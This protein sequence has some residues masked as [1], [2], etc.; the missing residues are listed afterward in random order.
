MELTKLKGNTY[1]VDG[2]AYSLLYVAG[3]GRCILLDCPQFGEFEEFDA[4]LTGAGL[5]PAAAILSHG[6][7]D[8]S[9]CLHLLQQKY[10]TRL[11]ATLGEAGRIFDT[12]ALSDFMGYLSPGYLQQGFLTHCALTADEII[13]PGQSSVTVEGAAFRVVPSAGH[14]PAHICI[15]TPDGILFCGDALISLDQVA[16]Q[17]MTYSLCVADQMASARRLMEN[18]PELAVLSHRGLVEKADFAELCQ[19]NIDHLEACVL[20]LLEVIQAQPMSMDEICAAYSRGLNMT[21]VTL[22]KPRKAVILRRIGRSYVEYLIDTGR[23]EPHL[24]N[25]IFR[26]SRARKGAQA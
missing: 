7:F 13:M 23:L 2:L 12:T 11:I 14:S 4:L 3:P 19:V 21:K 16:R 10:G 17:K 8:H 6:H 20:S 25:G 22:D 24:Q 18:P 26:F 1:L 5:V 15:E 9:G